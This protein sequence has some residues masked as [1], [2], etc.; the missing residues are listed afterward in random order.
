MPKDEIVTLRISSDFKRYLE[1]RARADGLTV[2]ELVRSQ[3][4]DGFEEAQ[5][6]AIKALTPEDLDMAHRMGRSPLQYWRSKQDMQRSHRTAHEVHEALID[7]GYSSDLLA[8]MDAEE[9]NWLLGQHEAGQSTPE[10]G[11]SARAL[12]IIK[13][14][15]GTPREHIK[16]RRR[17]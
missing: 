8:E 6:E 3:F 1:E 2:S 16:Y 13:G 12:H 4:V 11:L 5:S 7:A 10:M 15:R 14:M 17:R 9:W